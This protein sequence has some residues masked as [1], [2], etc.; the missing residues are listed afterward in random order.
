MKKNDLFARVCFPCLS[1]ALGLLLGGCVPDEVEEKNEGSDE[2]TYGSIPA[3]LMAGEGLSDVI[4]CGINVN[5]YWPAPK[6]DD[7][8]C[9]VVSGTEFNITMT[10]KYAHCPFSFSNYEELDQFVVWREKKLE[11]VTHELNATKAVLGNDIASPEY[12]YAGVRAEPLITADKTLFGRESGTNLAD[13]FFA[14]PSVFGMITAS[15]P[16]YAIVHNGW[17]D[18]RPQT[19]AKLFAVGNALPAPASGLVKL[20]Y[21]ETPPEQ[22]DTLNF[23]IEI[24]YHR[25]LMMKAVF[26]KDYNNYYYDHNY[27]DRNENHTLKGSVSVHFVR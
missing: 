8:A 27:L 16:T 15:Y 6:D 17:L 21:A 23:T 19:F 4:V 13:K 2:F 7:G 18:K 10:L 20:Y 22:Y 12:A 25:E 11:A 24:P 5:D 14:E 1:I 3:C 9:Q 26:G